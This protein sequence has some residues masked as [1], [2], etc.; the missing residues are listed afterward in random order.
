MCSN[1]LTN[2][3]EAKNLI[4]NWMAYIGVVGG[5]IGAKEKEMRH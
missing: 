2:S 1:N 5:M 4:E 3:S